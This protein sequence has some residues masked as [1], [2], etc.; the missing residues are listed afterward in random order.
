V[1]VEH[2]FWSTCDGVAIPK[3]LPCKGNYNN[4]VEMSTGLKLP[5]IPMNR[6]RECARCCSSRQEQER[7][8]R[9]LTQTHT[10]GRSLARWRSSSQRA[11][12]NAFFVCRKT[13]SNENHPSRF[14]REQ[15]IVPFPEGAGCFCPVMPARHC[16]RL[17]AVGGSTGQNS[18]R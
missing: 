18:L 1:W 9:R 12:S 7:V 17:G 10:D 15:N 6:D 8:S 16:K 13:A 3:A 2:L 5:A 11:Q 14:Q 4:F